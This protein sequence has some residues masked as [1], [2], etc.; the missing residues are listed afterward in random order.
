LEAKIASTQT[1]TL[2]SLLLVYFSKL[3]A[4]RLAFFPYDPEF[5]GCGFCNMLAAPYPESTDWLHL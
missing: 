1:L 4:W 5:T 3:A 2:A